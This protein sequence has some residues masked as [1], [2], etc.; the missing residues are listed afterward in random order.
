MNHIGMKKN[1]SRVN[2]KAL[3]VFTLVLLIITTVMC[4]KVRALSVE[5]QDSKKMFFLQV[6][7]YTLPVVKVTTFDEEDMAESDYSFI[8]KSLS[9]FGLNVNSPL[10]IMNKEVAYLVPKGSKDV[11]INNA[12]ASL[13][14]FKL[15]SSGINLNPK[16]TDTPGSGT[17][18]E[19]LVDRKVET[20]NPSLA[21]N[22]D[23][24]K[25]AVFI[26]HTHT[27]EAYGLKDYNTNDETKSVV[28]VGDALAKELETKYGIA[29]VHDKTVHNAGAFLKSYSR[30][31]ETVDKYLKQFGDFK[32]I[33]DLHRDAVGKDNKKAVTTKMNGENVAKYMFV[34]G[35]KNPHLNKNLD[36]VKKMVGIS[37]SLYPGFARSAKDGKGLYYYSNAYFNQ[38]KSNNSVLIEV[39]AEE[40]T[41][42][43]S[44]ASAKYL[45]RIIAQTI[46]GKN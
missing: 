40:N 37:E 16:S 30:S 29:V 21:Q 25:P 39:G 33:I 3:L 13:D 36:L 27:T 42:D 31:G 19:G 28:A 35:T 23:K 9:L 11:P 1:C 18:N 34:L 46:N 24:S 38:Q 45:A 20:F 14:P 32:I 26:Y 43:E 10:S 4:K 12:V 8:K 15:N 41:I 5:S 22:L 6:L 17:V 44:T 2:T 7:N